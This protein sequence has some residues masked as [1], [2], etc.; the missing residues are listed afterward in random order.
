MEYYKYFVKQYNTW[1]VV[2]LKKMTEKYS[3]F[4]A[5]LSLAEK[6]EYQK[7]KNEKRRREFVL[8]HY[9][10]KKAVQILLN[11]KDDIEKYQ[12]KHGVW[13]QPIIEI[14]KNV[15]I[16]LSHCEEYVVAIAF[17][18]M[19][20]CAV[21]IEQ[22]KSSNDKLIMYYLTPNE[23]EIMKDSSSLEYTVLWTAKEAISKVLMTGLTTEM[24]V[25]EIKNFEYSGEQYKGEYS[26]FKQYYF[27][28][29][30]IGCNMLTL[31]LP[32]KG[33]MI[34]MEKETIME[35]SER[36]TS[37][38]LVKVLRMKLREM[39]NY[40]YI[41]IDQDTKEAIIIDPSWE[42]EIIKE[43]VY[44][45]DAKV[46]GIM[47][48]HYH[49]DHTNLVDKLVQIYNCTV[50]ICLDEINYYNFKCKNMEPLFDMGEI[51]VGRK[52]ILCI[53][54]PGHTQGS[55]CFMVDDMIFTG[56][57]LFMEGVGLC[58]MK[59]GDAGE[60][61]ESI[62]KIKKYISNTTRVFPGHAYYMPVGKTYMEV[63]NNNIYLQIEDKEKFI[64]F[65]NR[66]NRLPIDFI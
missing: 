13:G 55:M 2:C 66:K 65:R 44:K 62:R 52:K 36:S 5:F 14:G 40:T 64:E 24:S 3:E 18:E 29:R 49:F 6:K 57:T 19:Y 46:K 22:I 59:G 26:N 11:Q 38:L 23:K 7:L 39:I 37:N 21:D 45:E 17:E 27:L 54:T 25:F 56:D 31:V 30:Q 47:L 12:I 16:S 10:E 53:E 15:K 8:G 42:E 32:K 34:L 9:V 48:T 41:I 51:S 28:S 35:F 61:Y 33:E 4:I 60:M 43:T 1:V 20:P 50:Y 58:D 63:Y